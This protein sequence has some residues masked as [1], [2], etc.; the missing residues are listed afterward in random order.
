LNSIS[1]FNGFLKTIWRA[2][3]KDNLDV[4]MVLTTFLLAVF[5][6]VNVTFQVVGSDG[7]TVFFNLP[8]TNVGFF[9]HTFVVNNIWVDWNRW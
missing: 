9:D 4:L 2:F 3:W 7:T 6:L 8:V 1:G 5:S